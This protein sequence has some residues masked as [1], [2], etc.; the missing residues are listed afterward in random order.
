MHGTIV[1]SSEFLWRGGSN[2]N[3]LLGLLMEICMGCEGF[4]F[5]WPAV[6]I[7]RKRVREANGMKQSVM[8]AQLTS[9]FQQSIG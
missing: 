8:A 9:S 7:L 6:L 5:G 4:V 2:T 3:E 1:I